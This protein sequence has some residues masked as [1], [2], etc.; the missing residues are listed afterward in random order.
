MM[1]LQ[2]ALQKTFLTCKTENLP[3]SITIPFLRDFCFTQQGI[4]RRRVFRHPTIPLPFYL[5]V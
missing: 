5:S 3:H 1:T 2:G 4:P